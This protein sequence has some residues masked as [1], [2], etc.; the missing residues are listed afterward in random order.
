VS[1]PRCP[2]V[3]VVCAAPLAAEALSAAFD[4]VADVLPLPAGRPD[5]AGLLESLRPAGVV[6]DERHDA[7]AAT[8]YSRRSGAPLLHVQLRDSTLTV[9]EDH[10]WRASGKAVSPEHV[11]NVVLAAIAASR[12][13]P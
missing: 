12:S 10:G 2:V 3:A 5:L 7:E 4:G 13:L 1:T 11:R 6:V 8:G 9:W